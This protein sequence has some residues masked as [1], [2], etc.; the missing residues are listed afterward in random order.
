MWR[1]FHVGRNIF[2]FYTLFAA[3]FRGLHWKERMLHF[4]SNCVKKTKIVQRWKHKLMNWKNR[5]KNYKSMKLNQKSMYLNGFTGFCYCSK[6]IP[7]CLPIVPQFIIP[8]CVFREIHPLAQLIPQSQ[9]DSS[10]SSITCNVCNEVWM[11]SN[12]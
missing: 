2:L 12:A 10:T 11:K 1:F 9:E 8:Q 4:R 3:L 7:N 5:L 6:I